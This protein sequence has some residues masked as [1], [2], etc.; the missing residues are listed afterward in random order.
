[1]REAFSCLF[2]RLDIFRLAHMTGH[3]QLAC[4]YLAGWHTGIDSQKRKKEILIIMRIGLVGRVSEPFSLG[5][6]VKKG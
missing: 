6:W 3:V 5:C 2:V 4:R 1:M